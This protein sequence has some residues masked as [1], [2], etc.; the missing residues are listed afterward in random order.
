MI[1]RV[2]Y[3]D[4]LRGFSMF[5]VIFV[6]ISNLSI[7]VWTPLVEVINTYLL[8]IFFFISGYVCY[9]SDVKWSINIAWKSI[10]SKFKQLIVPAIVMLPFYCLWTHQSFYSQLT[11]GL[12]S[13]WFL[14]CLFEVFFLYI[15]VSLLCHY[16]SNKLK[17]PLLILLSILG[18]IYLASNIRNNSLDIP[19]GLENLAKYFQY[20]VFGLILKKYNDILINCLENI[21]FRAFILGLFCVLISLLSINMP[22]IV[23]KINHDI[24]VRYISILFLVV[25]FYSL[26]DFFENETRI[27]KYLK[28][29]GNRSL[30]IFL[31]QGFFL[32]DLK[33][34]RPYIGG[35]KESILFE[36]IV[37]L[38]CS[39][40]LLS[41]CLG[42]SWIIRR[43]I[44]LSRLCLGTK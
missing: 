29:I 22:T 43:S 41:I 14:F 6:H 34:L 40:V 42:V 31:F 27:S 17:L 39:I 1:K 8:P 23:Y 10:F 30:D 35:G 15:I 18:I 12:Y 11:N 33:F 19:L 13:Y 38:F 2:A 21:Y 9:K 37:C 24:V 5:S 16:T 4:A 28:L 20:F 44:I 26:K 36:I 7:G 25:I 3:I 32:P